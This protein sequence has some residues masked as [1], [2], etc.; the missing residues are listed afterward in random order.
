MNLN[1]LG[2]EINMFLQHSQ[3]A[4]WLYKFSS[5]HVSGVRKN[6]CILHFSA[7]ENYTLEALC[8]KMTLNFYISP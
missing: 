8:Q 4:F 7:P 5:N 3:K 1:S 2:I 6:I